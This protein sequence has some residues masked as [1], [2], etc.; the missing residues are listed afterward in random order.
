MS[1][2]YHVFVCATKRPDG[3]PRGCCASKGGGQPVLER[4]LGVINERN[5]WGASIGV[6]QASCLGFCGIGPAI[7][8]YPEGIWYKLDKVEDIDEIVQSHFLDGTP[9][10]R[11]RVH[12]TQ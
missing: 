9:V 8:V 11:L 4:L 5:L 10:E 6:S 3:H 1:Y 12:P 2:K 7:V